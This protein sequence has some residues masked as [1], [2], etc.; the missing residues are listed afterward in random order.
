MSLHPE[1]PTSSPEETRRVARAAFPK[2]TLCL[3]IADALGPIYRDSQFA[4]LFPQLGQPAA[5]PAM[6]ALATVLQY[7]EGLSDRQTAINL[8]RIANWVNGI[9]TA[10]TRCSWFAAL[11]KAA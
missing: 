7:L 10:Q 9:P 4:G 8:V 11:Q 2:G 3:D 6:L 1:D 5:A